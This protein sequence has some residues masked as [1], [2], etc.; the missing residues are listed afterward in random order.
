MLCECGASSLSPLW[1]YSFEESPETSALF[2]KVSWSV[3][4]GLA[5]QNV[6]LGFMFKLTVS[7]ILKNCPL[8]S[9]SLSLL[10]ND[11]WDNF[12]FYILSNMFRRSVTP[13]YTTLSF[14]F[15]DACVL[16]T[17][18][19]LSFVCDDVQAWKI[20]G[21]FAGIRLSISHCSHI[22]WQNFEQM[23]FDWD[24]HIKKYLQAC[25]NDQC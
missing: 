16:S 3:M 18:R 9:L 1:D 17:G 2:L 14:L 22:V 25:N 15:S 21:C 8:L 6:W 20:H 5:S 23:L 13:L 11:W 10:K 24:K 19:S 4:L 12:C 7:K